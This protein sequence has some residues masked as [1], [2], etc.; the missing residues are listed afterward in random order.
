MA[1]DDRRDL[2]IRERAGL[3]ES[4]INQDFKDFLQRWGGTVLTVVAVAALGYLGYQR[5]TA[6]KVETTTTAFQALNQQLESS[7][8]SP[9]NLL[10]VA[11]DHAS[12]PGVASAARL[13]AA[14][15]YLNIVRQGVAPGAVTNEDGTLQNPADVLSPEDREKNLKLAAE[16][17]KWVL[18][19]SSADPAKAL[20]AI[21]AL[22]GLA[23]V[24]ESRGN[25]DE[26]KT[27]YERIITLSK[28]WGEGGHAKLAQERIDSLPTLAALTALPEK[29]MVPAP[30]NTAP[31]APAAELPA[32]GLNLGGAA[33]EPTAVPAQP[34]PA[35][36]P[37]PAPAPTPAPEEP[38]KP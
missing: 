23:A 30:L 17:Y 8:P 5:W 20:D 1:T 31:P 3:E 16:N 26:A 18:D 36:E 24:A 12:T 29:A 28:P 2:Q 38:K 37:A 10:G 32:A 27:H 15:A 19:N 11:L 35:T 6:R 21:G 22:Y 25:M 13:A 14:D 4:L 9:E 34:A 33:V 7:N